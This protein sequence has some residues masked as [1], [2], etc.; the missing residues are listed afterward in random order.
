[1]YDWVE[2]NDLTV[3]NRVN[4]WLKKGRIVM[5]NLT[6]ESKEFNRVSRNLYLENLSL[7]LAKQKKV[8]EIINSRVKITPNLIKDLMK[9]GEV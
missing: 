3:Y 9:D 4:E 7:S 1:M 5:K 8:I 2:N 6:L